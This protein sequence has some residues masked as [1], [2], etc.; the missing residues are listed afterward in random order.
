[1]SQ[2]ELAQSGMPLPTT[3]ALNYAR[4]TARA[5]GRALPDRQLGSWRER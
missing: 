1:M 5:V 2:N 3:N 4:A